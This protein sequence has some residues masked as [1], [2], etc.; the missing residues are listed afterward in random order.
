MGLLK[1]CFLAGC[2]AG[3]LLTPCYGRSHDNQ[4]QVPSRVSVTASAAPNSS[5]DKFTFQLKFYPAPNN[6]GEGTI[7]CMFQVKLAL[8]YTAQHFTTTSTAINDEQSVYNFSLNLSP[9][10]ASG[11]W[12]LKAVRIEGPL[13]GTTDLTVQDK[14]EFQI[15]APTPIRVHFEDLPTRL[16]AG[17]PF[18]IKIVVDE[19]PKNIR[20][21]CV[22]VMG[23]E[24]AAENT[25]PPISSSAILQTELQPDQN[26]Y[27][28]KGKL[29]P[30]AR[31]GTWRGRF[32]LAA[33]SKVAM[34]GLSCDVP[35]L[36]DVAP[37]TVAVQGGPLPVVPTMVSVTVH[38]SQAKLLS[39]EA[40]RINAKVA[41][42]SDQLKSVKF[43]DSERLLFDGLRQAL[44]DVDGTEKMFR[45][46]A[47]PEDSVKAIAAFF[48]DIRYQYSKPLELIGKT[49]SAAG[50]LPHVMRA[51]VNTSQQLKAVSRAVLGSMIHNAKA[52]EL[53]SASDSLFFDLKVYSD[54]EGAAISYRHRGEDDYEKASE[55][56]TVLIR[57]LEIGVY[58]IR[59]KRD[60]CLEQTVPYDAVANPDRSL[61]ISLKCKRGSK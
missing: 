15:P 28:L 16:I 53:V 14:V 11:N 55:P 50:E 56:T 26:V 31:G 54:P 44:T 29:A 43:A 38:P 20:S 51:S 40:N 22:V 59:S 60:G 4:P 37:F 1:R 52:Y 27:E 30:Y 18:S 8:D 24:L 19:Y 39:G 7:T 34:R 36:S 42:I 45:Q 48:D 47:T 23:V 10:M 57:N 9:E 12:Q 46:Q 21:P 3:L 33:I 6:I 13:I 2:A 17:Q 49:Q 58:D 35:T 5:P 61:H 25:G 41:K 32:R